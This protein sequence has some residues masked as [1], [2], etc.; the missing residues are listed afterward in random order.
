MGY[1]FLGEGEVVS[2]SMDFSALTNQLA[3]SINATTILTIM[4]TVV[5]ATVGIFLAVWGGR[6]IVNGIQNALKRGRISA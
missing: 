5:G 3:S 4:G 6:K 1:L 2:S